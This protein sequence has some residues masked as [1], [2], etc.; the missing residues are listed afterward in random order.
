MGTG[1]R[2]LTQYRTPSHHRALSQTGTLNEDRAYLS[3]ASWPAQG[4]AAL[5]LGNGTAAASPDEQPVPIASL[6]KVMTAYL[7]LERYPLSGT[8]DG[9][10][11]SVTPAEAEEAAQDAAQDESDVAVAVGRATDRAPAARG[12][13]DPL[14]QQHRPAARRPGGG[15]RHAL[16]RRD[17]RQGPRAR[18]EPHD[19]H[20]SQRVRVRA[21]SPPPPTSCASSSARCASRSFARSSRRP[22]VTLP[23]AGTLTNYDPLIG[24]GYAGKT[25]SDAAAGGCLAF[26][27]N[28]TV[29]RAPTDRDRRR[30]GTGAGQRHI[31]APGCSRAGGPAARLLRRPRCAHR[32]CAREVRRAWRA[33]RPP[34]PTQHR[35]PLGAE[36]MSRKPD[37]QENA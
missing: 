37:P 19:L 5:V 16:H 30:D 35:S 21:P 7:T 9:F 25:G 26:F 11:I 22:A 6:A 31:R 34:P 2:A 29:E 12:V 15:Q 13:A 14:R 28:V 3:A 33:Q 8:Q 10:T 4:Q 27:T 32:T 24:E 36:L 17:E 23:V 20:R 18:D 1:D